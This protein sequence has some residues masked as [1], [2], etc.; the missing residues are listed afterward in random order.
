MRTQD[1]DYH[2]PEDRI[3]RVP[4][5]RGSARLLVLD[6]E[7]DERHREVSALPR[8]L[9]RGD[10][11]VVNDTRVLPARL[12]AVRTPGGA[13]IELLLLDGDEPRRW[14]ALA[15]P[16]KKL[17]AGTTLR[18]G[19]S[20][21]VEVEARGEG[22]V[23]TLRFSAPVHDVLE[24]WGAVPLPPY[25]KRAPLPEDRDWYQTIYAAEP[26]AVAAPT[27]GLHLTGE[28]LTEL[29]TAGVEVAAITLHVGPGTF[30][31][32]KVERVEDHHLDAER[33]LLPEATVR[34][35]EAARARGGRVVAVGTTVV[36]CLEAAALAA[37]A[38]DSI[39]RREPALAAGAGS[40]DLF[41]QPGFAFRV[42]DLLLTNFHLPRSTL[43]MLVAAFA[44]RERVLAAYREAIA[45]GYRFYSY[46]DAMVAARR[47]DAP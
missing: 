21:E 31:P 9:R 29:Q 10:L 7:G 38:G 3:A 12:E 40:T 28:M 44:G 1:F 16:A 13:R 8:L 20:V 32:V 24:R 17:R 22:G 30:K 15:R 43:L 23:F 42:V 18:V 41:I 39:A 26:G 33:Y 47:C 37:D 46:G 25:L 11:L 6:A 36:R 2:L 4:V 19:E 27:A 5:T 34:A 45:V 14:R 35:I